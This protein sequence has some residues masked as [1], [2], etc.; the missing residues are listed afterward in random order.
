MRKK[1]L[2]LMAMVFAF[3]A[4]LTGCGGN[5]SDAGST[6]ASGGG[7]KDKGQIKLGFVCMNLGNPWFVSVKKGFEDA[8]KEEGVEVLTI[9]SQYK[10]DKQVSDMESL[11]SA[12]YSGIM[13]APIDQNAT[14][15]IVE[16]AKAAGIA[17]SCV[18]QSQ[19]N[20]NMRYIVDEHTY[21]EAIG[22]QAAEWINKNL[23]SK[24][25][26][27][28][29]IISQDNV[30][31]VIPRGDGV[32]EIIKKMCPN[33]EIVARQ[34]GDTPELGMKIIES[35]LQ[36]HPD[37]SVVVA[38][39]DSGGLG[40][41]QAMV[42][43]H[44]SGEDKAVF[45]GD[46]TAECLADMKKPNSIYRGTVDLFPYKAGYESAKTLIK[47]IREGIPAQQETTIFAP[48]PVPVEDLLSGKYVPKG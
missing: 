6:S 29:A 5:S 44:I 22:K 25:K 39:N 7:A 47:Y 2:L 26:V 43:A 30:D 41:Y 48:V 18:A 13:L 27:K 17:T 36:Q 9:D 45:S 32:E 15:S 34:A 3:S 14:K 1:V 20:V 37:L 10:V 24:D 28:V 33:V 23:A 40:G 21:G 8:C 19:D 35:V 42:S 12:G 11:V 16:K 38:T 4:I 31:S 46:A